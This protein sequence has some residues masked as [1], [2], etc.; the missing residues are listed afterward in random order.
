MLERAM[1]RVVNIFDTQDPLY[2]RSE[3]PGTQVQHNY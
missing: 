2:A 3:S 1:R